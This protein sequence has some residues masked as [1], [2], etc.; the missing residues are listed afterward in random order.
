MA[1]AKVKTKSV[2]WS[3][4]SITQLAVAGALVLL[5]LL[6]IWLGITR[7]MLKRNMVAGLQAMDRGMQGAVDGYLSAAVSWKP[8]HHPAR[9]ALAKHYVDTMNEAGAEDMY[10]Q[11]LEAPDFTQKP[12]ATCGLGAL[13]LKKAERAKDAAGMQAALKIAVDHYKSSGDLPE[14]KIGLA[15]CELVAAVRAN[16][17]A[18]IG[19]LKGTFATLH[20]NYRNSGAN[21]TKDGLIDLYSGLG[22]THAWGGGYS[23]DAA[24]YFNA[25][26]GLAP[27]WPL[28]MINRAYLEAARYRDTDI[29]PKDLDVEKPRIDEVRSEWKMLY[30]QGNYG[31]LKEAWFQY[32]LATAYRFGVNGNHNA[33]SNYLNNLK[34]ETEFKNR[35]ETWRLEIGT[36]M[37]LGARSTDNLEA[38]NNDMGRAGMQI[39]QFLD[40]E[41]ARRTEE[42]WLRLR[43]I[44]LVNMA[45]SLEQNMMYGNFPPAGEDAV[46][47]LKDAIKIEKELKMNDGQGSYEANR[48]LAVMLRRLGKPEAQAAFD[49]AVKLAGTSPKGADDVKLLQDF[50]AGKIKE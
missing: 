24:Q 2:E 25:C 29:N 44:A 5:S 32:S 10:R 39:R 43:A 34:S 15:H 8:T 18:K 11:L 7:F 21:I 42:A 47:R 37:R 19:A 48:N 33:F 14:A 9:L 45:V 4:Q 35:P 3:S 49:A 30:G 38:R 13:Y 12:L 50:F 31:G 46:N 40:D 22:L 1:I 23:K 36:L 20:K 16:D 26:Y 41:V 27:R 17:S 6:F 28:P